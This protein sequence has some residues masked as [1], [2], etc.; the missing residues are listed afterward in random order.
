[1]T[2]SCLKYRVVVKTHSV[3]DS[4]MRERGGRGERREREEREEREKERERER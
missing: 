3:V 1:M 2:N 4:L